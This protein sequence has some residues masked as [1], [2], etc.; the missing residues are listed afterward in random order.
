MIINSNNNKFVLTASDLSF[1][2]TT[3]YSFIIST[4][5][6]S[7]GKYN[8]YYWTFGDRLT[9]SDTYPNHTYNLGTFI[10]DLYGY[11]SLGSLENIDSFTIKTKYFYIDKNSG[12][13]KATTFNFTTNYS[14]LTSYN[15]FLWNFGDGQYSR[16]PEPT[17]TYETP[18]SYKVTYTAYDD[19][20]NYIQDT[21]NI[22]IS[23]FLNES[24]Y[25]DFVP[26][27]TF[28]GHLNRYP[29][30]INITSSTT[31]PHY[32]D[33]SSQ[34]SKSYEYQEPQNK[35]SFLRPQWRFLD[36]SGNQINTIKTLDTPISIDDSGILNL[37][38]TV[39]GVTGTAEFYF[40]DDLYNF[41][42]Y[43]SNQPYTT[44]IATLQTSAIAANDKVYNTDSTLPSFANSKAV[45]SLPYIF[46]WREPDYINITEN[47]IQQISKIKFTK[48]NIPILL[49]LGFSN[50]YTLDDLADGNQTQVANIFEF[51]HYVPYNSTYTFPIQL[52]AYNFDNTFLNLSYSPS[53]IN[54]QYYDNSGYRSGGYYKGSL[55]SNISSIDCYIKASANFKLIDTISKFFNP[56]LW[57]SN[58]NAGTI[59]NSVYFN[60]QNINLN[61]T[62]KYLN[63]FYV[64][65]FEMPV[66]YGSNNINNPW[67]IDG[68]H[69]INS[70]AALPSPTY[71]A[72]MVDSELNSIYRVNSKGDI[73][74]NIDIAKLD[75]NSN[76]TLLTK[77]IYDYQGFTTNYPAYSPA[78][79]TLDSKKNLWVTFHDTTRV[80]KFDNLGNLI[81]Y[82]NNP[83]V[84]DFTKVASI[85]TPNTDYF[86][87]V[88]STVP[89]NATNSD[90]DYTSFGPYNDIIIKPTGIDTDL[91]DNIWVT[92]SSPFSSWLVKYSSLGIPITSF[93]FPIN[94]CPEEIV[95]DNSNNI[96]IVF[97]ESVGKNQ[98]Y[99]QKRNSFGRVLSS[100][101][102]LNNIN[103]ITLDINQNP[104]FTY[105]Y[106]QLGSLDKFGNLQSISVQDNSYSDYPPNWFD[107]IINA[108]FTSLEGIACDVKNNIYVINSIENKIIVY[109][110]NNINN[111]K[112]SFNINPK[113][114]TFSISASN[115]PTEVSYHAWNK[116]AQA[117]GDWS[118]FKWYNKYSTLYYNNTSNYTKSGNSYYKSLSGNSNINYKTGILK[119]FSIYDGNYYDLFKVNENFDLSSQMKSVSFQP[120]LREN[121]P[122]L[123]DNFLSSIFN[124]GGF[125][126]HD[127][128][129]IQS[130]EKIANFVSN[131]SD[132]DTCNINSL[133]DLAKSVNLDSDDFRLNYPIDIGKSMDLLS[134]NESRIFGE[135]LNDSFN[136]QY[137]SEYYNFNIGNE[138]NTESY[139]VSAGVPVVLCDNMKDSQNINHCRVINTGKL[140]SNSNT[141]P[142]NLIV[143]G[144]TTYTLNQLA[145]SLNILDIESKNCL[146]KFYEYI[147]S[148]N[149]VITNNVIDW[150][151]TN[152]DRTSIL[153]YFKGISSSNIPDYYLKWDSDEG[154][155][156]F[157]FTYQLYKGF[158]LL[159]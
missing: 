30:K 157:I 75:K 54:F 121:S 85:V 67:G 149:D 89:E 114:F 84:A 43:I 45:V 120:T 7:S 56:I 12:Y 5:I 101:G 139:I 76:Y 81:T 8:S 159:E 147:P 70:I 46:N 108:D 107:P 36:L 24:I 60:Q 44:I 136:F 68:Y 42:S 125:S 53:N 97:S 133:Y 49:N 142:K 118:G 92:Y 74:V 83:V 95:C 87:S 90:I 19:S 11:N 88:I 132:I 77:N 109:D 66:T 23:L 9:S 134:I 21:D 1:A 63:N 15:S 123:Y 50:N 32:I 143:N 2:Q 144:L 37:S 103:H 158:G 69:G 100:Y 6:I 138:L 51:A 145:T 110:G 13:A 146:Y 105:G 126:K 47:G 18:G 150:S 58:P 34:F 55:S 111:K 52:S 38:G 135:K 102:Y 128:L 33:L 39:V 31:D 72:W 3:N 78:Y 122:M 16:E 73:L 61:T 80:L 65:N 22:Q 62:Q 151:N 96:W 112:G 48:Q 14:L 155:M 71:H 129:G 127:A 4:D 93:S 40:V 124:L 152:L 117:S 10:I 79:I 98:S 130:Y 28:A 26:P 140:D 57:I 86:N 119:Y 141:D 17:H 35:W 29:F 20:G 116:S 106:N 99:L 148:K 25:F 59:S 104:W 153:N 94:T 27:P 156:E 154:L 91:N 41:D 137:P 131:Q 113:G 64:N 82:N 115:Q